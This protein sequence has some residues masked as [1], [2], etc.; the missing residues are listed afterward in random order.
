MKKFLLV[1]LLLCSSAFA[2]VIG[3]EHTR[4]NQGQPFMRIYNTTEAYLSCYYKDE[5]NSSIWSI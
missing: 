4:N 2:Q 5:V 3:E 1:F